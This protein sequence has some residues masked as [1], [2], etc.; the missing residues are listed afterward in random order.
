[1]EKLAALVPLPRAHLVRYEGCLAPHSK[2]RDAIRPTPCQQGVDGEATPP[3]TPYW[4][5]TR[6]LGRVLDPE[7]ATCPFCRRGAPRLIAVITQE[8]V[9]RHIL[10][11][12]QLAAV[13]PPLT[14]ARGRHALFAFDEAHNPWC[15][16]IGDVHAAPATS[17]VPSSLPCLPP[18]AVPRPA[19]PEPP[20]DAPR[21]PPRPPVQAARSGAAPR[22]GRRGALSPPLSPSARGGRQWRPAAG[23]AGRKCRLYYLSS[24]LTQVRDIA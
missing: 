9:I 3:G 14:P 4:P 2:L 12:L 15:R 17:R 22:G 5:W 1:L 24:H 13:P 19:L 10:R 8:S 7:M 20:G 23:V 21:T 18:L 6:L 16:P 11:H